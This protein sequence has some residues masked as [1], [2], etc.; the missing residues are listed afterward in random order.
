MTINIKRP[1]DGTEHGVVWYRHHG[2]K[3]AK[4]FRS[5]MENRD[6]DILQFPVGLIGFEMPL[7]VPF[8]VEASNA[9]PVCGATVRAWFKW[10][11][12]M[13]MDLHPTSSLWTPSP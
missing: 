12:G 6:I 9:C 13:V 1:G 3:N 7:N 8:V 5:M 10:T 2:C 11:G 4:E